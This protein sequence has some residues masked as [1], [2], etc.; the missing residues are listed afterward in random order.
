MRGSLKCRSLHNLHCACRPSNPEG[1]DH[2]KTN[3][4]RLSLHVS[5]LAACL[6]PRGWCLSKC[7]IAEH[8][9]TCDLQLCIPQVSKPAEEDLA[10]W[11]HHASGATVPDKVMH[12]VQAEHPSIISFVFTNQVLLCTAAITHLAAA[13]QS[14]GCTVANTLYMPD[15]SMATLHLSSC[16]QQSAC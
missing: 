9:A 5:I 1:L 4:G 3:P 16:H 15:C 12:L 14:C 7:P 10:S 8:R 2:P 6:S 13:S 11:G